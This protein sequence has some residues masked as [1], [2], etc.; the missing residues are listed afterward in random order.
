MVCVCVS[1][2]VKP[3]E[4]VQ[5]QERVRTGQS[6]GGTGQGRKGHGKYIEVQEGKDR[7]KGQRG[8]EQVLTKTMKT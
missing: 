4:Q 6:R 2:S 3:L 8:K 5:G 1:E 7:A